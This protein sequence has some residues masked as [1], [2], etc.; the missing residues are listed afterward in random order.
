MG[1]RGV[2]GRV[3]ATSRARSAVVSVIH[4]EMV[5]GSPPASRAVAGEL[6]IAVRDPRR[7]LAIRAI[8]RCGR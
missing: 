3:L 8:D 7:D 5:A 6:A 4:R 2:T 1:A